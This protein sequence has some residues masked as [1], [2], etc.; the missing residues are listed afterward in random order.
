M[1]EKRELLTMSWSQK[2]VKQSVDRVMTI[3]F[4]D[5][6]K[7]FDKTIALTGKSCPAISKWRKRFHKYRV[8]GIKDANRS[9]KPKTITPE[10]NH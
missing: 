5:E 8:E 2:L 7:S 6:G 10:Q 3:L 4:S 9:C 1:E